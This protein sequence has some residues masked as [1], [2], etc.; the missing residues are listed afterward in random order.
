VL[1]AHL[2]KWRYQPKI[3]SLSWQ[4]TIEEHR[5]RVAKLLTDSPSLKHKIESC[6]QEAHGDAILIILKETPLNKSDIPASCPYTFEQIMSDDFLPGQEF[7][8]EQRRPMALGHI[9]LMGHKTGV[10]IA[11]CDSIPRPA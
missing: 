2:L 5:R 10:K 6:I 3:R 1:I 9:G 7:P 8:L 4:Y 11:N